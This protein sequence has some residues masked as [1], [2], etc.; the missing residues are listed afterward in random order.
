MTK[1]RLYVDE[2]GNSNYS[3]SDEVNHKYLSLTGIV[4]S[5]TDEE[6]PLKP[7]INDLKHTI[8]GDYDNDFSLHRVDIK[9]RN[10]HYAPLSDRDIERAW[11][12]KVKSMLQ[13]VDYRIITVTIDKHRHKSKYE[14]PQH[15]YYYCLELLLERYAK[16][17][18]FMNCTGDVMIEAR[19]KKEDN[20]LSRQYSRVYEQG[21]FYYSGAYMQSV[22]TSKEI[23]IKDKKA[24]IPGLELADMLSLASMLDVLLTY[25]KIK[26]IIS[27]FTQTIID[28]AQPKYY[29]GP[30]G[31]VK[32]NGKKLI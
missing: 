5:D 10:G 22:L 3:K 21:T 30:S 9:E 27:Q 8:T 15:P 12:G 7:R 17:L 20:E 18:K 13:A 31:Q 11:N 4:L 2:S 23:K 32:G 26:N 6:Y 25:G 24:V 16:F 28:L 1:F 29:V 19:G 14:S